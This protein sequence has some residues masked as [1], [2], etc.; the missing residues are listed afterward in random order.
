MKMKGGLIVRLEILVAIIIIYVASIIGVI[1]YKKT[2]PDDYKWYIAWVVFVDFAFTAA[3]LLPP[4]LG[5]WN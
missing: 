3:L 1:V 2:Q 4:Y 5:Q